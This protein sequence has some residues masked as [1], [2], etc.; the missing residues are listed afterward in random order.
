MQRDEKAKLLP[1]SPA[2][3]CRISE[4]WP[5]S[6]GTCIFWAEIET[7]APAIIGEPRQG[8]CFGAPPQMVPIMNQGKIVGAMNMRP[9]LPSTEQA[10]GAF[11][12]KARV[13]FGSPMNK[14]AN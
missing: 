4:G 8:Y 3:I 7:V 14:G 6:C 13:A 2:R 9:Q 11:N 5:F 10:C 12:A 1:N